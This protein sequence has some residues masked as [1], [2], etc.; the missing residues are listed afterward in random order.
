MTRSWPSTVSGRLITRPCRRIL[1]AS[2][3]TSSTLTINLTLINPI[4]GMWKLNRICQISIHFAL[5]LSRSKIRSNRSKQKSTTE[6]MSL[7]MLFHSSVMKENSTA[8]PAI[9]HMHLR[10]KN[11]TQS[12]IR[13][14]RPRSTLCD[15][16]RAYEE[17]AYKVQSLSKEISED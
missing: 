1:T 8:N 4:Q 13:W 7:T 14:H 15:Y 17:E 6:R 16:F 9:S 3:V 10:P 5:R 2:I 12:T 11:W